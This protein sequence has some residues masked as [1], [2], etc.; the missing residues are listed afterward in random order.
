MTMRL[1][2]LALAAE[3]GGLAAL[4]AE[5]PAE[6]V[7][8][9]AQLTRRLQMK[10]Q[11]LAEA[12][13]GPTPAHLSVLFGG[14]PVRGVESIDVEFAAKALDRL[15]TIIKKQI[16][17]LEIGPLPERGPL[18]ARTNARLAIT[19]LEHQSFGFRLE[20]V[21]DQHQ[22]I[23]ESP[24]VGAVEEVVSMLSD[25]G[26]EDFNTFEAALDRTDPRQLPTLREFFA[27]LDDSEAVVRLAAAIQDRTLDAPRV[28]RARVRVDAVNVNEREDDTIVGRLL[29][30]TPVS[31]RFDMAL[32]PSGELIRGAV[33]S[34]YST[35]YLQQLAREGVDAVSGKLWVTRMRIREISE[36]NREPRRSFVLINLLRLFEPPVA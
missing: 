34:V 10:K 20:E 18:N 27:L 19:A 7:L 2:R 11:E 23:A 21:D 33:S 35:A 13:H 36:P 25:L 17:A 9:R 15:Q 12:D 29:G 24:L 4:L 3:V 22:G 6:D 1:D 8:G 16:A 14:R 30:I 26:D 31:R 5:V 28:R 32:Y